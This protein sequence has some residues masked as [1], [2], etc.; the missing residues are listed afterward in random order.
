MNPFYSEIEMEN[1]K[2]P[3]CGALPI[4]TPE[5]LYVCPRCGVVLGKTLIDIMPQRKN[6][7]VQKANS[8]IKRH[9]THKI[10]GA[11]LYPAIAAS[12]PHKPPPDP[13]VGTALEYLRLDK[14][15]TLGRKS[16][17]L[18]AIAYAIVKLV[19]GYGITAAL[20]EAAS[21]YNVSEKTLRLLVSKH[22]STIMLAKERVAESWRRSRLSNT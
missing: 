12:S 4:I 3:R 16:R 5:G 2:C 14:T 10:F 1:I 8:H 11:K 22:R 6:R 7:P 19:E 18:E 17:T 15:L 9:L 20:R 21:R 13:I